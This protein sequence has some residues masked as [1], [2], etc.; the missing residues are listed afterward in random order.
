MS[1]REVERRQREGVRK[2]KVEKSEIDE[3]EWIIVGRDKK[4]QCKTESYKWSNNIW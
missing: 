3:W 4:K 2:E 1:D